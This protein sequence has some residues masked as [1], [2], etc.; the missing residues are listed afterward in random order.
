MIPY[1][2]QEI[3]RKDINSVIKVL[4]SK[5]ITQGPQVP[6]FENKICDYV[7]SKYAVAVNSA[8]SALHISCLALNLKKNDILW[9]V[10]N[11]FVASA[12]CGLYCGAKIDFVDIDP[13]SWNISIAKLEEKLKIAKKIKKLPKILVSVHFT[14]QPTIQEKIKNLSNKFGFLII[15]DA[16]HS[17]GALR[18]SIRVG[19][20]KWSD[21]TVFSFHPVKMITTGEGGMAVTNNKKIYMK[22]KMYREHGITRDK[23]LISKKSG[24]AF[25]KSLGRSPQFE[26]QLLGYNYRMTDI[27]AALGISQMGKLEKFLK[28]RNSLANYY[29]K[30]LKKNKNIQLQQIDKKNYSSYHIFVIRIKL[31][32]IKNDYTYIFDKLRKNNIIVNLH[33]LPVHLHPYYQKL[34]FKAGD[35]PESEKYSK[36]ALTI[37]LFTTITRKQQDYVIEQINKYCV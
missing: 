3:D 19:S 27:S 28:K 9:T 16:S 24:G 11:T 31:D 12:N 7:S 34:G 36:E 37:P 32:Q 5:L 33:Y 2:T 29:I 4:K 6:K 26:Q 35:Y 21:I 13:L 10:P 1:G 22:L 25:F 23:E 8:T 18:N 14:G 17:L 30:K 20:C 15:E